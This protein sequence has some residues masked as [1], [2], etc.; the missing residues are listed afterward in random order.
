[1]CSGVNRYRATYNGAIWGRFKLQRGAHEIGPIMH[2]AKSNPR[3][4][5]LHRWK[6]Q[7]VIADGEQNGFIMTRKL[8][9]DLVGL[10]VA[11][12]IGN[13]LLRNFVSLLD[14]V[15]WQGGNPANG[16]KNAVDL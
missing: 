9:L 16:P 11:N 5:I 10:R 14:S 15:L 8:D 3:A 13:R 6:G 1:M 4:L 2:D 7:A 12:G